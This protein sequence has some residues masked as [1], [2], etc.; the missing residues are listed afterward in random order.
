MIDV[1]KRSTRVAS[2]QAKPSY[3]GSTVVAIALGNSVYVWHAPTS[4]TT[5]LMRTHSMN[6]P[7]SSLKW[8]R[9]GSK[10]AVGTTSASVQIWDAEKCSRIRNFQG[11]RDRVSVMA[12]QSQPRGLLS[13]AGRD[14][15]IRNHDM[16]CVDNV[17]VYRLHAQEVCGLSWSPDNSQL[18][19]GGNDNVCM[20]WD[21]Q[22][23]VNSNRP[24]LQLTRHVAAIKAL[25][26]CPFQNRLLATGGGTAD[27]HIRFW[28]TNNGKCFG[29]VDTQSQVCGIV[30]STH[31]RELLTAHG[32]SKNQLTIWKY[33]S[34]TKVADLTGHSKRVLHLAMSPDETTVCS[35]SADETLRFWKVFRAPDRKGAESVRSNTKSGRA[36]GVLKSLH[37]R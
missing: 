21:A 28:N 19:S 26:W 2:P 11:H 32:F 37:I 30:W 24:R 10:L 9:D 23:S 36:G 4:T 22:Q 1:F 27:R 33:P 17:G 6:D 29:G 25:A 16:R 20:V 5:L 12:W 18:A 8:S 35:A 13:T 3:F 31:E 15:T 7:I 34:M 14:S